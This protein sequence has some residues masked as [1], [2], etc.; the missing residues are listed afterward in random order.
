MKWLTVLVV[1]IAIA[2]S[3]LAALL[4]ATG[5]TDGASPLFGAIE[6]DFLCREVCVKAHDDANL[7][8]FGALF[9]KQGLT[10]IRHNSR[11]K[12]EPPSHGLAR[13]V[14]LFDLRPVK[15]DQA[16]G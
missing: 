16:V 10:F 12:L 7:T 6:H 13:R 9:Q 1:A 8:R 4:Y 14:R 3:I 11:P 5:R 2:A 15:A